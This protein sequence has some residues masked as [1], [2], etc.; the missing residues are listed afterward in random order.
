MSLKGQAPTTMSYNHND[1]EITFDSSSEIVHG[2][3]P[4]PL[5]MNTSRSYSRRLTERTTNILR[6]DNDID[7]Q[8][9]PTKMFGNFISI[10]D[11]NLCFSNSLQD[12]ISELPL[13]DEL[14]LFA[15]ETLKG[16]GQY[17][18]SNHQEALHE[19]NA[20]PVHALDNF[21]FD[22][23]L[24]EPYK[25]DLTNPCHN[26]TKILFSP[27]VEENESVKVNQ[28]SNMHCD[29]HKQQDQRGTNS[30]QARCA[31]FTVTPTTTDILLGRGFHL[32]KRPGNKHF[33]SL[34]NEL[35]PLY[36]QQHSRMGKSEVISIIMKTVKSYQGRFLQ[37]EGKDPLVYTVASCEKIYKKCSQMLRANSS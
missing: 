28:P 21:K 25:I 29:N 13:S 14:I 4:I 19:L 15:R 37:I 22:N 6:S 23:L 10:H 3:D 31:S 8:C 17:Y 11:D 30:F 34:I 35:K 36:L 18:S 26:T 5:S 20:V 33:Q 1:I 9:L 24:Y 12:D 2:I 16:P 27:D 32:K 7:E